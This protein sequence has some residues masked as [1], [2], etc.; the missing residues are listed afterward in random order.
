MEDSTREITDLT[1]L[2]KIDLRFWAV[3]IS[4]V[5]FG[6]FAHGMMLFNKYSWHD[7]SFQMFGVGSSYS[8]GWKLR[9]PRIILTRDPS[10][11]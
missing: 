9:I 7:D 8:S 1:L 11:L 4:S 5:C 3:L 6:L 2:K 10:R